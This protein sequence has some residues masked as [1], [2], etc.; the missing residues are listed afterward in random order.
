MKRNPA[1]LR[2]LLIDIRQH[3]GL[4]QA[5]FAKVLSKFGRGY[6]KQQISARTIGKIERDEAY[7]K[8]VHIEKYADYIRI[9]S[10]LL[11]LFSRMRANKRDNH[12][13]ESNLYVAQQL[14]S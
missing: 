7:I 14:S 8:Y 11:L 4:D 12:R 13:N 1:S 5:E 10:G 6:G 3:S 2:E 9:P